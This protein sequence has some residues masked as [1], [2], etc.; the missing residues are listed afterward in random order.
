MNEENRIVPKEILCY[1]PTGGSHE[2]E[3]AENQ[4]MMT[5]PALGYWLSDST[6]GRGRI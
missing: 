6:F 2:K 5:A 4:G 3:A 1:I